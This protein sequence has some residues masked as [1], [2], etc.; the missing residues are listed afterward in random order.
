MC[1][2]FNAAPLAAITIPSILAGA[3]CN[4]NYSTS[5]TLLDVLVGGCTLV[6]LPIVAPTQPDSFDPNAPVAGAGGPY[7]LVETSG[8][9]T[10]CKDKTSAT[11]DLNTCLGAATYSAYFTFGTQRVIIKP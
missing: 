4:Q 9:V 1:G 6:I 7:T 3:A 2:D 8:H 5:D 10:S 11:V